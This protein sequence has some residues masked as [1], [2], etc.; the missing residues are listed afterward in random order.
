M[1]RK[2]FLVIT[3]IVALLC[4]A[5]FA[6][7]ATPQ[8]KAQVIPLNA[9]YCISEDGYGPISG[10]YVGNPSNIVGTGPDNNWAQIYGGSAGEGG[11]IIGG[12]SASI[13][14]GSSITVYAKA[15][16]GYPNSAL[17]VFVSPTLTGTYVLAGY[18]NVK[19]TSAV[20]Y[21]FTAPEQCQYI[22][23][24]G[25]NTSAPTDIFIDSVLS[26]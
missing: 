18:V 1:N 19:S 3:P 10:G 26:M 9:T 6:S 16:S 12:M 8:A 5:M 23:L 14:S 2:K 25:G 21:V 17:S 4:I 22:Y 13:N 15:A 20:W 7:L 24:A 11:Y